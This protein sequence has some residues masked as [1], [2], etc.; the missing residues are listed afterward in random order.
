M[1]RSI[2]LKY[3][4]DKI[5]NDYL[6]IGYNILIRGFY[7]LLII[8][9]YLCLLICYV[10]NILCNVSTLSVWRVFAVSVSILSKLIKNNL[11]I[12]LILD[13]KYHKIWKITII[14]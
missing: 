12:P 7:I 5:N 8:I 10:K 4:Y 9:E 3:A 6:V 1:F 2:V 13:G 14:I 11:S